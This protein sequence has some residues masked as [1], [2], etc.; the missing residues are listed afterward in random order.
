M[1]AVA[2]LSALRSL[3]GAVRHVV[4]FAAVTLLLWLKHARGLRRREVM[5]D[6]DADGTVVLN[7]SEAAQ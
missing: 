1:L 2:Q 5:L 7:L 3:Q 6:A 4:F